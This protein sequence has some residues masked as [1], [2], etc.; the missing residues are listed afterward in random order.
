M[1]AESDFWAGNA[2]VHLAECGPRIPGPHGCL[3]R[4]CGDGLEN[5][6]PPWG[7]PQTT[8]TKKHMWGH[9]IIIFHRTWTRS[10]PN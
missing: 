5:L 2:P 9:Q 6:D 3:G 8:V 10:G 7:R 4:A 1:Q